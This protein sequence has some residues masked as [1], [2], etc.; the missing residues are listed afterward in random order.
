M[1]PGLLGGLLC[2]SLAGCGGLDEQMVLATVGEME[3]S[4]DDLLE[5]ESRLSGDRLSEKPGAAGYLDY[6]QTLIDKELMLQEARRRGLDQ[7]PQLRGKLSKERAD[8][9]IKRFLKLEVYDKIEYTEEEL[10]ELQEQ[11]GRD[12]AIRVRRIVLRTEEEADEVAAAWRRG[13]DFGELAARTVLEETD[14]SGGRWLLK[15]EL[16]PEILQ[17]KVW[18]LEP[19]EI[20]DPVFYGNQYGV[21]QVTE[22]RDIELKLVR[23]LIEPELFGL[24]IPV[25]MNELAAQLKQKLEARTNEAALDLLAERL[26]AG[27][28]FSDEERKMVLFE[29][30]GGAYT[31][32]DF[33][34]FS[35]YIKMGYGDSRRILDWFAKEVV[36]PRLLI[37]EAARAAGIDSEEEMVSWH[38]GREQSLLLQAV[39]REAT[40]NVLVDE[41]E[42][43]Q[44]Y[45]QNPIKFTPLESVTIREILV[46]SEAEAEALLEQI[47]QG[48]D[49]G[50]LAERNTLRRQGRISKGEF[51]IHPFEAGR[52]GPAL[53]AAREAEVGD[54]L[55]PVEL[56]VP[57]SELVN[58]DP[59][60]AAGPH[61]SIF[62]LLDSTIGAAPEPFEKVERRARAL[63]RRDKADRAFYEF[64]LE[65]R[66]ENG[67]KVRIYDGNVEKLAANRA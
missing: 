47:R 18:P 14:L 12:R 27:E 22:E 20:S 56:T 15:D 44:Y 1:R 28:P 59:A 2:A 62:E 50:E 39:R 55:G 52:Y 61:F 43:R 24:K 29:N 11:T 54:L 41:S 5:F 66:Y 19:D 35:D 23:P 65:L 32:E 48:A 42:A 3:I 46:A 63:V 6:L 67:N 58:P 37:L 38:Q 13:T 21:Y 34:I 10:R 60:T 49:M 8:R 64:L 33:L 31:V 53:E 25:R 40:A 45:E 57:E 17:E 51:H 26:V 9:I 7:D 16:K 30:T 36:E 4:T